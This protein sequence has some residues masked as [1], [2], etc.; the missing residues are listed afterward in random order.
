MMY[1]A[2]LVMV[3]SLVLVLG[4][5][6]EGRQ[7][8]LTD[9]DPSTKSATEA[10]ASYEDAVFAL[11][12]NNSLIKV[13]P[14]S[15]R[16]ESQV[17]LGP[18]FEYA[19]AG[20][21]LTQSKDGSTLFALTPRGSNGM[22]EIAVID[23]VTSRVEDRYPLEAG[24]AFRSLVV[25]PESGR[26]YLFGN[27]PGKEIACPDLETCSEQDVVVVVLDANGGRVI[28][29]QTVREADGKA[30]TVYQSA[31]SSDERRLFVSY[32][33][34]TQ[35]VDWLTIT[36]DG[37]D[38]C[39]KRAP[40]W[41]GCI[42]AHSGVE[43]Y[44]DLALVSPGDTPWLEGRGQ[45]IKKVKK[46]DTKLE[47][48][49]MLDFKVDARTNRLYVLGS[50]GYTGGLSRVDL[51]TDRVKVLA[52]A[53]SDLHLDP[54]WERT[55]CGERIAHGP[56]SLLVVGKTRRS[57]PEAESSGSLLM[58]DGSSG[59]KIHTVAIPAEPLDVLVVSQL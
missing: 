26:L 16:T 10:R 11:L 43:A 18:P 13:A 49:H 45:D 21:Y 55:V 33:G 8:A 39:K 5:A 22:S 3:S 42:P 4:C 6:E 25:G 27:R 36:P 19:S 28:E 52:P 44:E 17:S 30:W 31:V 47:G 48:N 37:L 2:V 7:P 51:E 46:W 1:R 50:C 35:G 56:G 59:R 38:R 32:H 12:A 34:N 24:I 29:N 41:Q 23:V 40:T 15:D 58:L 57:V 9:S 54:A 14:G 20:H 53:R